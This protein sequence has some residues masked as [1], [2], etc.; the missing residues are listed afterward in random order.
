VTPVATGL[1]EIE[2]DTSALAAAA[3]VEMT[4][5]ARVGDVPRE[6]GCHTTIVS[7]TSP[8]MP[9]PKSR[10]H[11]TCY[12]SD[13]CQ[14]QEGVR[15]AAVLVCGDQAPGRF[16]SGHPFYATSAADGRVEWNLP[17]GFTYRFYYGEPRTTAKYVEQKIPATDEFYVGELTALPFRT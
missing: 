10:C 11:A 2:V 3:T 16:L 13:P 1:Y 14:P 7:T 12:T 6:K 9:P 8:V 15:C 5:A 17:Q 4:L